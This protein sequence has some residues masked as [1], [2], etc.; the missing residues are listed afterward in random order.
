MES[1]RE[2]ILA[3]TLECV[4]RYG[5][6]KT[7]VD[8]AARVA[9]MS[10]AT[11]YRYVPGGREQLIVETIGW[12][13]GRIVERVAAEVSGAADLEDLLARLLGSGRRAVVGHAVLQKVL[14][15]EPERLLSSLAVG[16]EWVVGFVRGFLAP[17]VESEGG[18]AG[19]SPEA[20][21][22]YLARVL[23]SFALAPAGW[24]LQDP[25]QV[26][27]LVRTEMLAGLLPDRWPA[28]TPV[29]PVEQHPPAPVVDRETDRS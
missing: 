4:E 7:T 29:D 14:Q 9:G 21:A 23:L 5:L 8:D 15:T 18:G 27:A 16:A 19:V 6:A 13:T 2:R 28:A 17:W 3:A 20:A 22:D 11:V 1:A 12:E 26:S 10:R 25:E 24:D